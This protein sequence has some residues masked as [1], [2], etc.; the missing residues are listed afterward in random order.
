MDRGHH[1]GRS[2]GS[3]LALLG[4][5]VGAVLSLTPWVT[6]GLALGLGSLLA[7]TLGNPLPALTARWAKRLLQM[8]VVGLGFGMSLGAVVAAGRSG[9][10][11]TIAG[12][13]LALTLGL[14]L[15]RW[16]RIE[17][18]I[19]FL[20]TAGTSI[21]GGSAIAA[22]GPAI[23]APSE[24]MSVALGT[25]FLLNAVALYLF[26][27]IGHLL[28]LGQHQFALWAAIAIHDTSSVVG[29]AASYGALS[30][31]EAT[32]L[33]LARALWIIPLTLLA[34]LVVRR[35]RIGSGVAPWVTIPWFIPLFVGAAAVRSLLPPLA[36]LALDG[37]ARASRVLLVLTLFLIGTGL[38]RSTLRAV[39]LRPLAQGV[40]LWMAVSSL[41]L[42]A[43]WQ[44]G[45]G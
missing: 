39:G 18:H 7:L 23:G 1:R 12:I 24:A 8:A 14:L 34:A 22:V 38:T 5:G 9:V 32:V 33:K 15:G 29:A 17:R 3:P 44:W 25:V 27:A 4:L 16:L 35:R 19:S 28:H 43:V 2:F 13:G 37:I 40:L 36:L 45:G 30:L 11:Y 42:L 6:P 21:C 10:G 26:P 31:H 41:T 20:I